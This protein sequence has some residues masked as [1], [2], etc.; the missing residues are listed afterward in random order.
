MTAHEFIAELFSRPQINVESNK[1]YISAPQ[2]ALLRD[3]IGQDD[4][5]GALQS[6]MN[7]GF[8]WMPS[9]CW[10][11]VLSQNLDGTRRALTRLNAGRATDA[12]SLFG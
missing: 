2:L 1:R 12:G 3:L 8:I 5:G 11:Y 10:K 9:G 6:G 7:G 4:E